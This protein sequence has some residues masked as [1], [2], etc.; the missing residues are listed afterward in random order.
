VTWS[1]AP[2]KATG[3]TSTG[4]YTLS[5]ASPGAFLDV[6]GYVYAGYAYAIDLRTLASN[7]GYTNPGS[8]LVVGLGP[9]LL[10]VLKGQPTQ[11]K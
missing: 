2:Q 10:Q 1:I 11:T 9:K 4:D 3:G 8:M 6:D 5:A 7:S